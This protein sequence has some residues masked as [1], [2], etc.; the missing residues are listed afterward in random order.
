MIANRGKIIEVSALMDIVDDGEVK[1]DR[2]AQLNVK[3]EDGLVSSILTDVITEP[4]VKTLRVQGDK[5]FVE[6]FVNYDKSNDAVIYGNGE[7]KKEHL[8]PKTRPDD[9]KNEIDEIENV[10]KN[11]SVEK[12][13]LAI[14]RG[15]ETMLVIAAA[16][17]SAKE[18][19]VIKI[20]YSKGYTLEAVGY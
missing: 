16:N 13:P 10:I 19:K 8:I 11:G 1:Y 12:S 14:E 18:G 7:D 15:L 4:S 2:V 20:D 6:W 9:F 5:G 3:T 17:K